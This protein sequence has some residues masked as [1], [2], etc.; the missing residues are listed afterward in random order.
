MLFFSDN[1]LELDLGVTIQNNLRALEQ[2]PQNP[3]VLEAE[4]VAW[5]SSLPK[6]KLFSFQARVLRR[7]I[8]LIDFHACKT[9]GIKSRQR[10]ALQSAAWPSCDP[11]VIASSILGAMAVTRHALGTSLLGPLLALLQ[12]QSNDTGLVL[13][14]MHLHLRRKDLYAALRVLESFFSRL[15]GLGTEQSL[16]VRFSPG[17]VALAVS[18][19]KCLKRPSA[20][21]RE[22]VQAA[23]F[24]YGR[25]GGIA[26]SLLTEAGV[27]LV[28]SPS[29]N[30]LDLAAAT[31]TRLHQE[32][33]T[34]PM[35]R[36]GVVAATAVHNLPASKEYAADMPS[37]ESLIK[38]VDVDGLI[39]LGVSFPAASSV[40]NKRP[41]DDDSAGERTLKKRSRRRLPKNV[42]NGQE[43]D[44]ERWLPL[45]DRSYYRPKGKKGRKKFTDATQGG[46]SR[47]VETLGLVGGGGVKVEKSSIGPSQKKKKKGKK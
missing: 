15:D 31:F 30:D 40:H 17:L 22:L 33:Q 42:I 32:T 10:R 44:P 26:T 47:Q 28:S 18:L 1:K 19:R 11:Y 14:I 3:F 9:A 24:W 35:T 41:F 38:S 39:Q 12:K 37:V 7:N 5:K 46:S 16:R 43:P 27:E 20:A 13:A 21:K 25:P 4:A 8:P 45:R 2:T 36:A 34:S 6:A 29:K 23:R